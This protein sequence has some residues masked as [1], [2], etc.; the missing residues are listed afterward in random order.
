MP[1]TRCGIRPV[2]LL[3]ARFL[4]ERKPAAPVAAC[5]MSHVWRLGPRRGRALVLALP[6][7]SDGLCR[8]HRQSIACPPPR[9]DQA[10]ASRR[11]TR[12]G[13]GSSQGEHEPVLRR[14]EA[15]AP[16]AGSAGCGKRDRRRRK[17]APA[18]T[19][20]KRADDRR[21]HRVRARRRAED[22]GLLRRD[23]RDR[24]RGEAARD[25]PARGRREGPGGDVRAEPAGWA[26][27]RPGAEVPRIA[28]SGLNLSACAGHCHAGPFGTKRGWGGQRPSM[29]SLGATAATP[30]SRGTP[31]PPRRVVSLTEGLALVLYRMPDAPDDVAA[32]P[33]TRP[34]G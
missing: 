32:C 12:L 17:P 22:V 10:A 3:M 34:P 15:D 19:T 33:A 23:E 27:R 11:A 21:A 9:R 2:P 20:V 8:A 14:R 4:P 30:R 7:P 28:P 16:H 1:T 6:G 29:A 13:P 31:G 5:L 26:S 18:R 24:R 25:R